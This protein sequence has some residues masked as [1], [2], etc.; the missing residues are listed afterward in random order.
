[1]KRAVRFYFCI[2]LLLLSIGFAVLLTACSE[3]EESGATWQEQYDLGVK[4][5]SEGNYEE[6]IVAFTAAIEIDPKRPEAYRKA[7]EAYEAMGDREGARAI[8]A[9]GYEET[10]DPRLAP[11]DDTASA[12]EETETAR[13]EE[14]ERALAEALSFQNPPELL[15]EP[16]YGLDDYCVP[17]TIYYQAPPDITESHGGGQ[18]SGSFQYY[19]EQIEYDDVEQWSWGYYAHAVNRDVV[20]VSSPAGS[21][22]IIHLWISCEDTPELYGV[23]HAGWRDIMM[24][25]TRA[26]VM[27]KLGCTPEQA[28]YAAEHST[29]FIYLYRDG[30]IQVDLEKEPL[31]AHDGVP[32]NRVDL[33]YQDTN[34]QGGFSLYSVALK[35]DSNDRLSEVS[36]S[37][38]ARLAEYVLGTG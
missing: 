23:L 17:A 37:N 19:G 14:L 28:A 6:A 33:Y 31:F 4:Y 20:H 38:K 7:A 30:S 32:Y 13:R 26:A 29:V 11:G 27:E 24:G 8:L 2:P 15:F 9:K 3:M 21:T 16:A 10:G 34:D 35:F 12:D 5:L 25:D 36:F 22:D 1:M 18:L